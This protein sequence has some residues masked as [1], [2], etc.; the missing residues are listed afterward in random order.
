MLPAVEMQSPNHWTVKESPVL[1]D[2][3]CYFNLLFCY[4]QI[5]D[6]VTVGGNNFFP[7]DI[8]R[9]LLGIGFCQPHHQRLNPQ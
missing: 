7:Q 1:Y 5:L 3:S 6:D 8:P 9:E 2:F 4:Q